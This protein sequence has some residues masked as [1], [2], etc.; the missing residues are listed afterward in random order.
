MGRQVLW[1]LLTSTTNHMLKLMSRSPPVVV[2]SRLLSVRV[3][4]VLAEFKVEVVHVFW[5]LGRGSTFSD[6]MA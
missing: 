1:L 4:H 2:R 3:A 5:P 6:R